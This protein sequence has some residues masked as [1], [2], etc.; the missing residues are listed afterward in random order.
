MRVDRLGRL[1]TDRSDRLRQRHRRGREVPGV[2]D[3]RERP[4]PAR[5]YSSFRSGKSDIWKM[6]A[7]GSG[8][9]RLTRTAALEDVPDWSSNGRKIV[10]A[11]PQARI[12][13]MNADG[14]GQRPLTKNALGR[15]VAWAS[16]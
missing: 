13:L 2:D 6:R 15:G 10:Y 5:A 8:K 16:A 7:D 1:C 3:E 11:G 9:K 14:M 4:R 12:W